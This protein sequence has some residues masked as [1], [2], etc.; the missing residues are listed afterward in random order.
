MEKT[1]NNF[2]LF[3]ISQMLQAYFHCRLFAFS[4][5]SLFSLQLLHLQSLSP[6]LPKF[7][8]IKTNKCNVFL[9]SVYT[10]HSQPIFKNQRDFRS[11]QQVSINLSFC[12]HDSTDHQP[13][14]KQTPY[15]AKSSASSKPNLKYG[16]FKTVLSNPAFIFLLRSKLFSFIIKFRRYFYSFLLTV[17]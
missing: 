5:V 15:H 4:F 6:S 13:P 1:T 12:R 17:Y 7:R 16:S 8:I 10:L 3:D 2:R 14:L 11:C 9:Y